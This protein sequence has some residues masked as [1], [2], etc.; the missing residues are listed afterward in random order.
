MKINCRMCGKKEV[1][2]ESNE[3]QMK[4]NVCEDCKT[5]KANK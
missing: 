1:T 5:K 2:V 3:F 4:D